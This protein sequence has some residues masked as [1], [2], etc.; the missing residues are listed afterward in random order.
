[1]PRKNLTKKQISELSMIKLV[2]RMKSLH[3]ISASRPKDAGTPVADI[4]ECVAIDRE[5]KKRLRIEMHKDKKM[6][7]NLSKK[8]IK[9]ADTSI[10][11]TRYCWLV[12]KGEIFPANEITVAD[13]KEILGIEDELHRRIIKAIGHDFYPPD[14]IK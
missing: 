3:A 1:M 8:E 11:N 7:M 13:A 10:L 9:T 14:K 5:L 6:K 2:C 4:R 12:R